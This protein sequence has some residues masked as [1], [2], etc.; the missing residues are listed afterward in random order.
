MCYVHNNSSQSKY[1]ALVELFKLQ[2]MKRGYSLPVIKEGIK[3]IKHK[4]RKEYLQLKMR[5]EGSSQL[6]LFKVA[7]NPIVHWKHL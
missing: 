3:D 2:L 7:H 4:K 1:L 6:L 5:K